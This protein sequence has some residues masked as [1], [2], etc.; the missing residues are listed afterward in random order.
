MVNPTTLPV[1]AGNGLLIS[2]EHKLK[3]VHLIDGIFQG[4]LDNSYQRDGFGIIQ[5][6]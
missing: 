3:R 2:R 6:S 5:T 1:E 4:D